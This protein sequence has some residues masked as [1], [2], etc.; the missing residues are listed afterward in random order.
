M[1]EHADEEFPQDSSKRVQPFLDCVAYPPIR[2]SRRGGRNTHL[3]NIAYM[4]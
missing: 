4:L 1:A 3:T 2:K